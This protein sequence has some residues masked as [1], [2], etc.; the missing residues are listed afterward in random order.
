MKISLLGQFGSGNSG[1]DGSLEAMLICLRRLRPDAELLCI[2]SNPT[3]V[4]SQYNIPS[5]SVGGP[6]LSNSWINALDRMLARLPRRLALLYGALAHFQMGDI[7]IIPGTGILDDFQERAFG[8]PFVIFC[9]CLVARLRQT[10]IAFISIGAGPI[11]N[12]LSRW[13]LRSAAKMASY[14]SYRDDYSLRYMKTIGLDVSGDRRYPDIAFDLPVPAPGTKA[15]PDNPLRIGVGIMHYRGWQ[16]EHPRSE[17]IYQ[18]Y[19]TKMSR[20]VAWLL[21]QGYH[22]SLLMGDVTDRKACD[23]LVAMLAPT[24]ASE[25]GA[26]LEIGSAR[27]LHDIMDQMSTVDAAVVSRYH[28]LVCALKLGRP[29]ISLAYAHKND[30]LMKDFRQDK[31]CRHIETFQ[32]DDLIDLLKSALADRE[33]VKEQIDFTNGRL[34]AELGEQQELLKRSLLSSSPT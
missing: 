2:C 26:L 22:V 34:K 24:I 14:R 4:R 9:W 7:M 27:S 13:F 18:E 1:N 31:F 12:R 21:D 33:L 3:V 5:I 28:N 32:V 10:K 23:D 19:I 15:H 16:S 29:T 6:A 8:W 17:A 20:F 30:D 11:T 25:D